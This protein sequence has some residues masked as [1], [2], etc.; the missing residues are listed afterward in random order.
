MV[1]VSGYRHTEEIVK[2]AI[3]LYIY[4]GSS[5]RAAERSME[6]MNFVFPFLG[7]VIPSHVTIREWVMK[8]GLDTYCK[9]CRNLSVEEAYAVV[10]DESI[11]IAEHKILL[12]LKTPAQHPGKPITHSDVEVVDI[13]VAPS[14]D[15]KAVKDSIERIGNKLGHL[16]EFA[17]TDNGSSLTKGLR[18][19]G[20]EGHRDISHTFGTFL[21]SVYDRDEQYMSLTKAMGNARHFALTDV[22]YLMPCNMRALARYM[23][24]FNWIHWAGDMMRADSKLTSKERKMYSFVWEHGSLVEELEEVAECYEKVMKLCKSEGLSFKTSEECRMIINRSLMGRGDRLTCLAEKLLGYFR[25]ESRLLKAAEESHNISSDII[26]SSFGYFKD[27]KSDNRMYG[28]TGLVLIL[29]L[30]TK[31]SSLESARNFDFKACLENTHASDVKDWSR[32]NLPENLAAKRTKILR[33][34]A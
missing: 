26:E 2:L 11:T 24:V 6:V 21:K 33:Q 17:V 1:S 15:G 31:I 10:F 19:A 27:R 22:D 3:L 8:A 18:E 4:S 29:P 13:H 20:I 28:V 12:G 14:H 25:K 7:L 9:S 23:N 32:K 30:H 16:P 5:F 34:T